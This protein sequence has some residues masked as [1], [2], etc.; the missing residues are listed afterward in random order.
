MDVAAFVLK[1]AKRM[2]AMNKYIR[3]LL[4]KATLKLLAIQGVGV[5]VEQ[6]KEVAAVKNV[7]NM[8]DSPCIF[9]IGANKGEYSLAV[10]EEI[11]T[12]KI[13]AFEPQQ[14]AF[15]KLIKHKEKIVVNHL[16]VSDS[17]REAIL[18]SNEAGSPLA[19]LS[20][21]K[22]D[23][24]NIPFEH[25]ESVKIVTLE[26]Y[27]QENSVEHIDLLKIDAEGEE[28]NILK[29]ALSLFESDQFSAVQ[30]EFG[31]C[32]IDSKTHFMDFYYFFKNYNF[33]LF[34]ILSNSSLYPIESYK[35]LYEIP[36]YQNF[37]AI[38]R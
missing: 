35:E 37:I 17:C 7:I 21:R 15:S 19:S 2:V 16:G 23:Y 18:F 9:D 13:H 36:I 38:K 32:N 14:H 6:K 4:E 22:L 12:A 5:G 25:T 10:L 27:C 34:R 33:K 29:G 11:P 20:K 28:F 26:K 8:Q 31:G 30:F 3:C 1:K 24:F